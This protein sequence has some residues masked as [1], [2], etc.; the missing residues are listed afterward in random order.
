MFVSSYR[1]ELIPL[2]DWLQATKR[3]PLVLRGAR[4]VG[5]SSLVQFFAAQ[6]NLTL[7]EVNLEK[8]KKLQTA[9]KTNNGALI[10]Q[11]F[12]L[13]CRKGAI[14]AP[15]S[16]LFIDEIQAIPE[17][18]EALRYLQEENPTLPIIAAGSLLE[19]TLA[20]HEYS[21]PV[22][23]IE[24]LFMGPLRFDEFLRAN[25]ENLLTDYLQSYQY[26]TPFSEIAHDQLI[27]WLRVFYMVGG[28]PEAVQSYVEHRDLAQVQKI[29]AAIISTYRDD[30]SK[31]AK[32][33][34]LLRLQ[35]ILDFLPA[36]IG[37][38]V[39]YVNIDRDAK[40]SELKSALFLLAKAQLIHLA[41]ATAANGVPLAS[42]AKRETFKPYFLDSGLLLSM[43]NAGSITPPSTIDDTFIN[44]GKLAEQFVAQELCGLH[45]V[46]TK[47]QLFYW[48]REAKQANAEID[49][50][51]QDRSSIIPIEVKAGKG[52]TLKSLQQF[53]ADKKSAF[54]VRFDSNRPSRQRVDVRLTHSQQAVSF[55]LYSF[56]LYMVATCLR[57]I[58]QDVAGSRES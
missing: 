37:E 50:L 43:L 8:H 26:D 12:Q 29:H 47:S 20:D 27:Q 56:P 2:R 58:G 21:M 5:K 41:Y 15:N 3:K 22:G 19:F 51:I 18:L 7:H 13:I 38:K 33:N 39:K 36:A 24:Y 32:Q 53:M 23:R 14:A 25:G 49:F 40:A 34:Q 9:I 6:Q 42:E 30:F 17:M 55:T 48:L 11:E 46:Q 28:M 35:Q 10:L 54:A 45:S 52:G 57:V 44:E 16:L 1:N 4:Q 31:Y